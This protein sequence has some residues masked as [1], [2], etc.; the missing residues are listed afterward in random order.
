MRM[1]MGRATYSHFSMVAHTDDAI[2]LPA[3]RLLNSPMPRKPTM[4]RANPPIRRP[5][6]EKQAPKTTRDMVAMLASIRP[7]PLPC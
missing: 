6:G 4:K 7:P 1:N 3:G 2:L 5:Q